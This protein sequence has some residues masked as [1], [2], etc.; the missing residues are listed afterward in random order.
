MPKNTAISIFQTRSVD[1]ATY[2][3]QINEGVEDAWRFNIIDNRQYW[4]TPKRVESHRIN[5][6]SH[7]VIGGGSSDNIVERGE[8]GTLELNL[9][10]PSVRTI[11][12]YTM[13]LVI[14]EI[15]GENPVNFFGA[16]FSGQAILA[17]TD[18][19]KILLRHAPESQ[20]IQSIA[21]LEALLERHP[22]QKLSTDPQFTLPLLELQ[23]SDTGVQKNYLINPETAKSPLFN[24]ATKNNAIHLIHSNKQAIPLQAAETIRD[25][26]ANILPIDII[27]IREHDIDD[28][29]SA[30]IFRVGRWLLGV[31]GHPDYRTQT[32]A[33]AFALGG[34]DEYYEPQ[35][36]QM[37]RL[38]AELR[39]AREPMGRFLL[40]N[41]LRHEANGKTQQ[42]SA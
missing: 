29:Q 9:Q 33:D 38:I 40:R 24:G 34:Y 10:N 7:T 21:E 39:V 41:F 14:Q 4:A 30:S 17:A 36:Y 20:D 22:L 35:P 1:K 3:T 18:L 11:L 42:H 25:R 19:V 23:H 8:E 27:A 32:L 26:I 5:A 31:Q 2:R 28:I 12:V 37:D 6:K 15:Q 13:Y 16:C